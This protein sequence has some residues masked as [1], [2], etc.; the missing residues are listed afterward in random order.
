MPEYEHTCSN[1]ECQFEWSETYSIKADPPEQ[2]PKCQLLTAQRMISGGSGKGIVQL[3]GNDLT[4]KIKSDATQLKKEMY[5]NEA[6]YANMLG[7]DKYQQIQTRMDKR[8]RG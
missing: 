2:C 1:V 8:K 6:T 7:N 5:S 4:D 3:T